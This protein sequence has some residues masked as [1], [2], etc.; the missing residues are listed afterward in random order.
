MNEYNIDK[1]LQGTTERTR[2]FTH[3]WLRNKL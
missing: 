3:V 1:P 2:Y